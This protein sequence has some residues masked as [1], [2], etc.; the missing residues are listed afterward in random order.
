M[1]VNG[2]TYM[3]S[4]QVS[5]LQGSVLRPAG[6]GWRALLNGSYAVTG[7]NPSNV[8]RVLPN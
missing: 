2:E 6:K 5:K 8:D 4:S 7:Y 1:T 3:R